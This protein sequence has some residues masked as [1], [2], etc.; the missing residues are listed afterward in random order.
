MALW[1]FAGLVGIYFIMLHLVLYGS[2]F[3]AWYNLGVFRQG[4]LRRPLLAHL[5]GV[6]NGPH[7]PLNHPFSD[8]HRI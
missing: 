6:S 7:K 2:R 1:V 3:P 4:I 5:R 8:P